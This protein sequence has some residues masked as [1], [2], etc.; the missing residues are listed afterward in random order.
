MFFPDRRQALL[1]ATRVL[2]R[3]GRLGIAV[4]DSLDENPA[5][6]TMVALLDRIAGRQA[7]EILSA[8]FVLGARRELLALF[9][10]PGVVPV[11]VATERGT[12]RFP[13]VRIMVESDLRG[14]LPLM[15]VV[16]PEDQI[17]RILADAERLLEPYVGQDGN[18][19][20]PISVHIVQGVKP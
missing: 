5:Y 20:F 4:W 16:L 3:A 15:G 10:D 6:S 14:W 13:S 1:E 18:V 19:T 8:P 17:A 12:A 9:A 7:A 2:A 11:E